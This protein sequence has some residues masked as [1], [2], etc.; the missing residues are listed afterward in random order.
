M[1][2]ARA[3]I[4]ISVLNGGWLHHDKAIVAAC[5]RS[6]A[7]SLS[8][9]RDHLTRRNLLKA[10]GRF[11]ISVVLSTDRRVRTLNRTYRGL[12]KPTN[13]LSF[14]AFDGV[15]PV[16]GPVLLGDVVLALE[17]TGREAKLENRPFRAHAVHLVAH[18]VLH[19]L[20]YH[21]T[22][23]RDARHMERLER[24]TLAALGFADP[25]AGSVVIQTPRKKSRKR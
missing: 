15:M 4:D 10:Q 17:T 7:M 19:L 6:A 16:T 8:V 22:V 24:L 25:Y 2:K 20:G 21:H 11:E 23:E 18:G 1:T 5:K 14:P 9:G 13:V 3:R 12:D